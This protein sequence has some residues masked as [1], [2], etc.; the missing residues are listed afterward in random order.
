MPII[1]MSNS[2]W[3]YNCE[4]QKYVRERIFNG[5]SYKMSMM[6]AVNIKKS[7]RKFDCISCGKTRGKGTRYVG[8]NYSRVCQFCME[9]WCNN[10]SKSLEEI[11]Q[12]IKETKKELI[13]N[14]D[15]WYKEALIG[16]LEIQSTQ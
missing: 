7:G 10:S 13:K 1:D 8:D 15:K 9:E 3:K 5:L 14:K 11:K 6:K 4:Q 16:D 2:S 12:S